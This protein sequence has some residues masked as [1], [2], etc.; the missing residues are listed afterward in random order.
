[1]SSCY[2]G[3]ENP[4]GPT[5]RDKYK[6]GHSNISTGPELCS[7]LRHGKWA[8]PGGY[9]LYFVTDDGGALCFDCARH[10]LFNIIHSI[11]NDVSDGWLTGYRGGTILTTRTTHKRKEGDNN[12]H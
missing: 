12:E 3:G 2:R 1:M 5:V 4:I 10:E 8:W 9:P 7:T 6:Y 11:R